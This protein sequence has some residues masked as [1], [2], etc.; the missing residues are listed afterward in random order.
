MSI[1]IKTS[2]SVVNDQ[3]FVLRSSTSRLRKKEHQILIILKERTPQYGASN[4]S[5]KELA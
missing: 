2:Q 5:L 3:S 4:N 1:K